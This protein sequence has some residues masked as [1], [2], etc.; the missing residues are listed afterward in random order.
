[1]VNTRT[2]ARVRHMR[3]HLR[4]HAASGRMRSAAPVGEQRSYVRQ[5]AISAS[6][7]TSTRVRAR[8]RSF[9]V[10][11]HREFAPKVLP[12][13]PITGHLWKRLGGYPGETAEKSNQISNGRHI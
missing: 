5:S 6:F 2:G 13:W 7:A 12:A 9:H 8:Q 11:D 1:M 10:L 3:V 4:A